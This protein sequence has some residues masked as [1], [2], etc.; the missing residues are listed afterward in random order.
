MKR[1]LPI[2]EIDDLRFTVEVDNGLLRNIENSREVLG[3]SFMEDKGTHYLLYRYPDTGVQM[4]PSF[5]SNVQAYTETEVPQMVKL[6]P[7]G[8]A[9][10]YG[11]EIDKLPERDLDLVGNAEL[12]ELRE[13]GVLPTVEIHGHIFHVYLRTGYLQPKDDY[14]TLGIPL[15]KLGYDPSG[16]RY[17][18]IYDTEKHTLFETDWDELTAIPKEAI[19]I[20]LPFDKVLD[21]Y[22]VAEKNGWIKYPDMSRSWFNEFPVRYN[23]VAQVLPWD[24][25]FVPDLIKENVERKKQEGKAVGERAGKVPKKQERTKIPF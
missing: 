4:P 1:E 24:E 25:T 21:P 6:D 2:Y 3:F 16:T 14:T 19:P 20:A 9:S 22:Y 13:Q 12:F 17:M 5:A 8:V 10:K 23:L 7:E 18:F 15:S 11:I